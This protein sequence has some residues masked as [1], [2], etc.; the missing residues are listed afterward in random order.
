MAVLPSLNGSQ[1]MP[2]V[3][4]K[5]FRSLF[6]MSP[7]MK[8]TV[9]AGS[10]ITSRID[11]PLSTGWN[12]EVVVLA[13]RAEVLPLEAGPHRDV[14]L[15]AP[16]V[17]DE[18]R[19]VVQGIVAIVRN[20]GHEPGRLILHLQRLGEAEIVPVRNESRLLA[21]VRSA[22]LIPGSCAAVS[23]RRRGGRTEPEGQRRETA[24]EV[25][26]VDPDLLQA[27]AELEPMVAEHRY[28]LSMT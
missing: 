15:P 17:L 9:V 28:A 5:L 22:P 13:Q 12:A 8:V 4:P 20:A 19:D 3:G 7:S 11:R 25:V 6:H 1:E 18:R 24:G 16:V 23:A 27:A 21:V 10:S 14:R 26:G 2:T